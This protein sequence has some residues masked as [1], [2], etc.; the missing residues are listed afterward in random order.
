MVLSIP[1]KNLTILNG[2]LFEYWLETV[3]GMIVELDCEFEPEKQKKSLDKA[4]NKY[5][6]IETMRKLQDLY[7]LDYNK[8]KLRA[9]LEKNIR[10]VEGK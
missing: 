5:G 9:T 4:I 1:P 6:K 8:P 2:G 3:N 10:Y 7:R